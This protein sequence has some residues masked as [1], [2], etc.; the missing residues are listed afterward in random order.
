MKT[1]I[2]S[3]LASVLTI[4]YASFPAVQAAPLDMIPRICIYFGFP[5]AVVLS[6][7]I[8]I[9]NHFIELSRFGRT[10]SA[11]VAKSGDGMALQPEANAA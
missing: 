6:A 9:L 1:F 4:V 8:L 11:E 5:S 2:F 10:V 7:I 3:Y